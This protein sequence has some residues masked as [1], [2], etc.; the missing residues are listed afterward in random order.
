MKQASLNTPTYRISFF[1][2]FRFGSL[3]VVDLEIRST[4]LLYPCLIFDVEETITEKEK[5]A[6]KLQGL[7]VTMTSRVIITIKTTKQLLE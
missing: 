7:I 4:H 1:E 3:F 5:Q 6:K 2:C